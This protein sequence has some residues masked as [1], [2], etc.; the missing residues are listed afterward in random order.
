MDNFDLAIVLI[1]CL[2]SLL[3]VSTKNLPC[4][5]FMQKPAVQLLLPG[6][7]WPTLNLIKGDEKSNRNLFTIK[8]IPIYIGSASDNTSS[9]SSTDLEHT[10]KT[11]FSCWDASLVL[12]KYMEKLQL[13]GI[14]SVLELGSGR[15]ISG[16]AAF[17][18]ILA[19]HQVVLTDVG[20]AVI[21]SL[22]N[23]VYEV[24]QLPRERISVMELD[25]TRPRSSPVMSSYSSS[26]S[27]T[28]PPTTPPHFDLIIAADVVW[29][30][31]LIEPLV[32]TMSGE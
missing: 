2:H 31:E 20:G 28:T 3:V 12:A 26:S 4:S 17:H 6:P 13:K 25:W 24:N 21:D 14:G 30:D 7:E 32:E 29:V 10:T 8:G 27:S 9:S 11:A 23:I 5:S 1:F 22:R 15:G 19:S 18:I 16:M